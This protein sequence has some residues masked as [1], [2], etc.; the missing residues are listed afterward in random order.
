MIRKLE[1]EDIDE[2]IK[3]CEENFEKEG[4]SYDMK[5]EFLFQFQD[6]LNHTEHYIFE[7]EGVIK[8]FGG[9]SNSWFDSC[10]FG[11]CNFF[12]KLEFQK[13]GIGTALVNHCINRIKELEGKMVLLTT[14]KVNFFKRFKFKLVEYPD[15]K[16]HFMQL[17]LSID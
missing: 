4:Y 7:D 14:M 17:I 10:I 12:V 3:I 5:A 11:L 2:C 1:K 9:L 8:G 16:W 6:T 13:Q 15:D